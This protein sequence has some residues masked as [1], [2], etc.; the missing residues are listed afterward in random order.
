MLMSRLAQGLNVAG[1]FID[2]IRTIVQ[3]TP[4]LLPPA[5]APQVNDYRATTEQMYK[6]DMEV[7][8][9]MMSLGSSGPYENSEEALQRTLC[10][11][12][13]PFYQ[14]A[15]P[16]ISEAFKAWRQR[17]QLAHQF[18]SS[19]R[20]ASLR[21]A[22]LFLLNVSFLSYGMRLLLA[23]QAS[24]YGA[25]RWLLVWAIAQPLERC[26][27]TMIDRT[28]LALDRNVIDV[29]K[30]QT[31]VDELAQRCRPFEQLFGRFT[32]G[33]RFCV[34]ERGYMGWVSLAAQQGD[35][36][37]SLAGTNILFALRKEKTGFYLMGDCY[38][39]GLMEGEAYTLEG[40]EEVYIRII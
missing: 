6:W 11:D 37:A 1:K 19:S 12:G 5:N 9:L 7:S 26:L 27:C 20:F 33:R 22:F 4:Y 10:F 36:I 8:L 35:E 16:E 17:I 38:L 15:S 31:Q 29:G 28:A 24:L 3:M 40:A 39:Q 13:G 25:F 30:L 32:L 34:T 21:T 2:R 14:P 18:Y 23:R